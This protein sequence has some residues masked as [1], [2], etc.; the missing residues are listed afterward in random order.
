M[1]AMSKS[2]K[3]ISI[4]IRL[5]IHLNP[6]IKGYGIFSRPT[7]NGTVNLDFTPGIESRFRIPWPQNPLAS[8]TADMD[9]P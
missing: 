3:Q 2:T 5:L 6:P 1:S 8:I 4:K 7:L 9:G